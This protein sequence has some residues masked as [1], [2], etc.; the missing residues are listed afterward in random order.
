MTIPPGTNLIGNP[1]YQVND[2]DYPQ[3]TASGWLQ[4][5][6]NNSFSLPNNL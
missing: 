1:F 5:L 4:F 6:N 2:L 3:N